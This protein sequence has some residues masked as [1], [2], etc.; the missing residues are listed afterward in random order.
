LIGAVQGFSLDDLQHAA[1]ANAPDA[2]ARHL[3]IRTEKDVRPGRFG[4]LLTRNLVDQLI[5]NEEG[6]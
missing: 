5:Y 6:N 4:I 3:E 2:P 1:V